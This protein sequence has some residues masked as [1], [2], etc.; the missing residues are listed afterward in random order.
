MV[1]FIYGFNKIFRNTSI[2]PKKKILHNNKIDKDLIELFN[3]EG[4]K[5]DD[6]E[7]WFEEICEPIPMII[8]IPEPKETRIVDRSQSTAKR[9]EAQRVQEEEQYKQKQLWIPPKVDDVKR[10]EVPNIDF[11]SIPS[12]LDAKFEK[13]DEDGALCATTIKPETTWTKQFQR[14]LL[15]KPSVVALDTDKLK[16]ERKQAYDLLDALSKS[17][18]LSFDH[19]TL[20]VIIASTHCFGESLMNTVLK[21][22]INPIEKVERS[23]MIIASSVHSQATS[24]LIMEDQ[25]DRASSFSPKLFIQ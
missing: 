8:E 22:N 19:A 3:N 2:Y 7:E 13:Y 14:S 6:E 12:Q 15:S 1:K 11:T 17:G 25:L 24:G 5:I 9:D 21:E 10:E 18:C 4:F 16:T 23:T 20:H